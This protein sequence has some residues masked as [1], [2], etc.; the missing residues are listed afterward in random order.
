MEVFI[1]LLIWSSKLASRA[2]FPVALVTDMT[3]MWECESCLQVPVHEH[4]ER[5][6]DSYTHDLW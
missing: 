3:G 6:H 1:L 5:E 4:K 2:Q